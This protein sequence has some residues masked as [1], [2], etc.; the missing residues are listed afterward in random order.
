MSIYHIFTTP[1]WILRISNLIT[2]YKHKDVYLTTNTN[3]KLKKKNSSND[4]SLAASAILFRSSAVSSTRYLE[5][6]A[7]V[8]KAEDAQSN[9]LELLFQFRQLYRWPQTNR[10]LDNS[11]YNHVAKYVWY[12]HMA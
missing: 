5:E 11:L 8:L 9:T 10:L 7:E 3:V 2:K 1:K 4:V 6:T 12:M